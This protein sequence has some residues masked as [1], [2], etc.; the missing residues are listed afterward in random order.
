MSVPP[1]GGDGISSRTGFVGYSWA[2]AARGTARAAKA[3]S[4]TPAARDTRLGG[5]FAWLTVKA[6]EAKRH[7]GDRNSAVYYGD[8]NGLYARI[9]PSRDAAPVPID[10]YMEQ[11]PAGWK[12]Y[13]INIDGMNLIENYRPTFAAKVRDPGFEG[14][15][16]ALSDRNSPE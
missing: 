4:A 3:A 6:V 2:S 11:T 15:I 16:K 10:Y 9:P 7:P 1:P 14:L 12:V 5:D 13:E 8:S